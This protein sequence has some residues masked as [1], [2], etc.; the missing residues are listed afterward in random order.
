MRDD[1]L[2]PVEKLDKNWALFRKLQIDLMATFEYMQ[3]YS[4]GQFNMK[5][6]KMSHDQIDSKIC[7]LASLSGAVA[8]RDKLIK[9][10]FELICPDGLIF[11][12]EN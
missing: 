10:Y 1:K 11:Y 5:P 6:E 7:A 4:N 8:T 2:P 12:F 9:R 3:S